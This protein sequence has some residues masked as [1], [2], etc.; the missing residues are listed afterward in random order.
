MLNNDVKTTL[1]NIVQAVDTKINKRL[2]EFEIGKKKSNF[3]TNSSFNFKN[4]L[5]KG[6]KKN[7][8]Q[9][10]FEIKADELFISEINSG[11]MVPAAY[12]T[13]IKNEPFENDLRVFFPQ[14]STD[15]DTV[16]VNRGVYATNNA[17]ITTEATQF[18]ESTNTL[19]AVSFSIDKLAHR[20]SLSEEFLGDLPGA[21]QFITSQIQGGLIEKMNANIITDVK[22]NDT[23]FAAGSF[24][25]AIESANEFDVLMVAINQLRLGNYNPDTILLNPDDFVKMSLLKD[26]T[27][28]YLRGTTGT[29]LV[30]N[31]QGVRITQS[32]AVTSGTYHVM[33]TSSYARYYNR[34]SLTVQVG[35]DGNDFSSGKRTAIAVHRGTLAIFDVKACVTGTFSNNKAALETA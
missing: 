31:V 20:F 25:L 18:A 5:L 30:E 34:E 2:D 33:D 32:P 8:G 24:A 9:R 15:S 23:D 10:E 21:S 35:F 3:N 12:E 7:V 6:L 27:N 14:G 4:Q 19:D 13:N 26:T 29:N 1:D 22:A 28:T 16:T 17:A 11:T